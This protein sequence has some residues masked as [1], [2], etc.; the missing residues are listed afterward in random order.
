MNFS[1]LPLSSSKITEFSNYAILLIVSNSGQKNAPA[2]RKAKPGRLGSCQT[3]I[4]G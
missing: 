4:A 2:A 1:A 3:F